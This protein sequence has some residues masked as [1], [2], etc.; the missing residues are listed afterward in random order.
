MSDTAVSHNKFYP[1]ALYLLALVPY[2]KILIPLPQN[3]SSDISYTL[4][5]FVSWI[6]ILVALTLTCHSLEFLH[7]NGHSLPNMFRMVSVFFR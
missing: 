5:N 2:R 6:S 4:S 1:L 7:Y 3:N